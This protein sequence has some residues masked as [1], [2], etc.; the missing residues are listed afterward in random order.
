[1]R[2]PSPRTPLQRRV[3]MLLSLILPSN[4]HL[5]MPLNLMPNNLDSKRIRSHL[6]NF[7]NPLLP[8]LKKKGA[9]CQ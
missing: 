8:T 5:E 4:N 1:M 7:K 2:G 3:K 6:A 9:I